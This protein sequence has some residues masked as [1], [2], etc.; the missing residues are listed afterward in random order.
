M[1][2]GG[3]G[4]AEENQQPPTQSGLALGCAGVVVEGA[5]HRLRDDRSETGTLSS[6]RPDSTPQRQVCQRP[7]S[8]SKKTSAGGGLRT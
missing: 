4:I 2:F 3:F 5:E 8:V 6:T 7:H 1:L